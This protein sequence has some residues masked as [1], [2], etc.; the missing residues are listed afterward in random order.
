MNEPVKKINIART[1]A[2]ILAVIYAVCLLYPWLMGA[3]VVRQDFSG[4][5]GLIYFVTFAALTT[6]IVGYIL[7]FWQENFASW[8]IV[9]SVPVLVVLDI[10]MHADISSVMHALSVHLTATV[11]KL[12]IMLLPV[13]ILYFC[14]RESRRLGEKSL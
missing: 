9:I 14:R 4:T 1:V 7:L 13:I 3:Y 10:P 2:R 8:L 11:F 6:L 12:A 5:L